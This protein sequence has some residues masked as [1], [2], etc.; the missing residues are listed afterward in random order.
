MTESPDERGAAPIRRRLPPDERRAQLLETALEVFARRGFGR[1]GHA[2]IAEAAGVAVSTVFFY[3]RT[4]EALVEAVLEEVGR[5]YLE[6]ARRVHQGVREG[7]DEV[8]EANEVNERDRSCREILLEH[9]KLFHDSL[10]THPH[11]ARLA[12]D[13]STAVREDL[14]PRYITFI[15]KLVAN[16]VR[17]IRRGQQTGEVAA[18]VDPETS[19]RMLIGSAQMTA[20]QKLM[21]ADPEQVDRMAALFIDA[22]LGRLAPAESSGPRR[23]ASGQTARGLRFEA[24]SASRRKGD[25]P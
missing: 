13:W 22:A 10:A 19:A 21:G 7:V 25:P 4:A 24:S 1:A 14:W 20:Q 11:H 12:L 16:H 8:D 2:E 9:R 18:E 23:V 17:T 3:F 5:F 6:L 15:E